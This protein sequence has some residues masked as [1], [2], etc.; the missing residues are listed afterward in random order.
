MGR[1]MAA[2]CAANAVCMHVQFFQQYEK[3]LTS[4]NYVTRRQSLKV[5]PSPH[6]RTL[7]SIVYIPSA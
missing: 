2:V 7:S 6:A 3:L 5:G 1:C 4:D